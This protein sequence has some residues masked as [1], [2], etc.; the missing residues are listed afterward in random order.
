LEILPLVVAGK[1]NK[2]IGLILSI[3]EKTVEK[4]VSEL[5]AKLN[6]RS[7]VEAV[8]WIVQEKWV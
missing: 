2:E 1:T 7:R 4:H 3:C 8:L 5:C 6:V